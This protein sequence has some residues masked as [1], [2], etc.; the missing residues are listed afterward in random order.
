[1]RIVFTG[2]SGV[3]KSTLIKALD[4]RL[5]SEY[6]RDI[7]QVR[8]RYGHFPQ[9]ERTLCA[10]ADR[11]YLMYH[12]ENFVTDRFFSDTYAYAR[13]YEH[14]SLIDIA[15][16]MFVN[17]YLEV[18]IFYVPVE[19]E[20]PKEEHL[21]R[22]MD[23]IQRTDEYIQQILQ[24]YRVPYITVSGT[25]EQRIALVQDAFDGWRDADEAIPRGSEEF[26][27]KSQIDGS[28]PFG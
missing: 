15:E 26:S 4:S 19:F 22:D 24:K 3:G 23:I 11:F 21:E 27:S 10:I 13:A 8:K 1:M 5:P 20:I 25:K 16:R 12:N 9:Y 17:W 14:L 6:L 7:D 28:K 2:S 18:K